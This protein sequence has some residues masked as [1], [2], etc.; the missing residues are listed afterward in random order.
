MTC[1]ILKV[2]MVLKHIY[3]FSDLFFVSLKNSWGNTKIYMEMQRTQIRQN[4]PGKFSWNTHTLRFQNTRQNYHNPD[5]WI[6]V[7]KC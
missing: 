7:D 2:A 4:N 3:G 5:S 6:K 1:H